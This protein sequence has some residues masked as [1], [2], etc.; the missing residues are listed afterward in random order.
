MD[1]ERPLKQM[2]PV[3]GY[4]GLYLVGDDGTVIAVRKIVPVGRNGGTDVRP[5]KTLVPSIHP[6]G[7]LRVWLSRNGRKTAKLVHRLVAEAFIPNPHGLPIVNH[8]DGNPANNDRRNLEWTT[9]RGNA[10]HAVVRGTI[11]PPR[12]QG[13]QNSQAR[14]TEAD[15]RAMRRMFAA[16]GNTAEV[17]RSFSMSRKAAYDICHHRRW[18]HVG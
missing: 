7:H 8:L 5:T 4:G 1:P 11:V 10:K 12:Q 14:L 16:C 6:N 17:A 18:K 9:L 2:K 13:T 3:V 15:V